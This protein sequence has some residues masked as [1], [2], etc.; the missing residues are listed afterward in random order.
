MINNSK[1]DI[2]LEKSLDYYYNFFKLRFYNN[3]LK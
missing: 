1:Y 3:N 2:I